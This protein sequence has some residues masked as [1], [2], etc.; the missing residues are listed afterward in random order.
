V[1]EA[2]RTDRNMFIPLAVV[3]PRSQ[4]F[5]AHPPSLVAG[6]GP[7]PLHVTGFALPCLGSI[8]TW[9]LP[10]L[11]LAVCVSMWR[12]EASQGLRWL[13]RGLA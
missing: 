9:V 12:M 7:V 4:R 10:L 5:G 6:R 8:S 11:L 3:M 13:Y 2:R 1:D